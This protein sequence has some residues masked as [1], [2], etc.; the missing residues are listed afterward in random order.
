M[1][2]VYKYRLYPTKG[3]RAA[4]VSILERL[5][6]LYNAA[7]LERKKAYENWKKSI[8]KKEQEHQ[9]KAIREDHPE[10]YGSL[11]FHLLQD[12]TTRIDRTFKAFFR[13][14]KLAKE[15]K[16]KTKSKKP[17]KPTKPGDPPKKKKSNVGYP[18][19]KG[20]G[21]YRTFT[22]KDIAH[23]NGAYI[24]ENGKRVHLSGVGDVKVRL[25]RPFEGVVKQISITR[26]NYG[27]WY[28]E[29]VCD[30]VP[31]KPLPPTGEATGIDL[32][33]ETFAALASGELIPNPRCGKQAER[34]VAKAQRRMSRRKKRSN[35]WRKA[36]AIVAK[37]KAAEKNRRNDHHHKVALDL[38]QSFDII[39][40]EDLNILGLARGWLSKQVHDAAWGTFLQMLKDKAES[41]GRELR[42][43]DPSGTSQIC[44]R[45]GAI[46][47]KDL[48]VR[49]HRCPYCGL[50]LNRDVNSARAVFE[51]G[52]GGPFVEADAEMRRLKKREAPTSAAEL[53]CA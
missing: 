51:R 4:M 47:P 52:M 29:Y 28:V 21:R 23:R 42:K 6:Q 34:A 31:A 39:C 37:R 43:V 9:L 7:L 33:I 25:H 30:N 32:G 1:R 12:V 16:L 11:H 36:V 8:S 40:V 5:R 2:R 15:G 49:V 53:R 10:E 35:R 22:F 13:R 44:S 50:V 38:V 27:H 17:R 18:R 14:A 20:R 24:L 46:V 3:Q 41:A 45:C 19:F 26:T 48:S